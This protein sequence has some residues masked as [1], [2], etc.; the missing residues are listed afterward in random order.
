MPC[1]PESANAAADD[2]KRRHASS[3]PAVSARRGW[4]GESF[5]VVGTGRLVFAFMF[6][7][8]LRGDLPLLLI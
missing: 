3:T 6:F 1:E 4:P 2:R 5:R 7:Q 8:L